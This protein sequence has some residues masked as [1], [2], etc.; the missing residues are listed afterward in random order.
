MT[1]AAPFTP[2]DAAPETVQRFARILGALA[3]LIAARRLDAAEGA[4]EFLNLTFVGELLAFGDLDEF[5]HFVELI[6]HLLE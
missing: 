3:G 5:E 1:T 6:N 2:T 4:A